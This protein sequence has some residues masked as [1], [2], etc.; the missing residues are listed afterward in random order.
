MHI[1]KKRGVLS[2]ETSRISQNAIS[3]QKKNVEDIMIQLT[4]DRI[5][6]ISSGATLTLLDVTRFGEQKYTKLFVCK[7]DKEDSENPIVGVLDLK[8]KNEL[9]SFVARTEIT[10]LHSTDIRKFGRK[11]S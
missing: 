9:T 1:H 6:T 3:L 4:P 7:D 5:P 2:S 10:E 11:H 8:V